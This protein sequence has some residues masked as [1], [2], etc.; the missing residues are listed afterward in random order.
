MRGSV[1]FTDDIV[2]QPPGDAKQWSAVVT[3]MIKVYGAPV[4]DADAKA[5]V[6]CLA[7]TYGPAR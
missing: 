4:G 5:I 7:A 2:I 3:T 6:E 1:A